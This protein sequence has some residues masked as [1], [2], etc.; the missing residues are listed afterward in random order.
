MVISSSGSST[1]GETHILACDVSLP[2]DLEDSPVLE[3]VGPKGMI[4]NG[5]IDGLKLFSSFSSPTMIISFDPLH[6]SHGGVYWCRVR[7][8]DPETSLSISANSSHNVTV[9][10]K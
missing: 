3:W 1:A 5:A 8:M 9:Q 6:T 2:Q 7:V 10:S 4:E